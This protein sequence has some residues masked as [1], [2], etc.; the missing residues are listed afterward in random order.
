MAM[1]LWRLRLTM[2]GT[3]TL[4]IGLSSLFLAV[5]LS[6]MGGF[7]A[8]TFIVLVLF[9]N[10]AQWLFSPYLIDRLYRARKIDESEMPWLHQALS[11]I[12]ERTRIQMPRL[13]LASIPIPNAFAY[14]SPVAGKR[15]AVTTGLLET[16]DQKEVEAVVGHEVGHLKHRDVQVMMFASILPAIFY[17]IGY[18]LMLSGWFGGSGRRGNGGSVAVLLG[19]GSLVAYFLLSLIVLGLGR[20]REY[21]ADRHAVETVDHG[22]DYLMSGLAKIVAFTGR[23]KL[24]ARQPE[25]PQAFKALFIADP[26]TSTRDFARLTESGL[27]EFRGPSGAMVEELLRKPVGF[28]DRVGE[29]FSSHPNI[30]RR[31]RTLQR[32]REA[33]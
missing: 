16:L 28:G 24:A 20:T 29:L 31:L 18:S 23:R 5:L 30:V 10:I 21:Y 15:I 27:L 4:L 22:A 17:F 12:C 6:F 14:G 2:L 32:L 1:G 19:I 3:L 25:T 9:F 8:L 11:N 26:D 33:A 13:M 7:N